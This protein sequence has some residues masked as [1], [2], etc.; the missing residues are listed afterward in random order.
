MHIGQIVTWNEAMEFKQKE[1]IVGLAFSKDELRIGEYHF[2]KL[3]D[4][5]YE[6]T[7]TLKSRVAVQSSVNII[8]DDSALK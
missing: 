3:I 1:K 7:S 6:L 4:G 5:R 2:S 8:R